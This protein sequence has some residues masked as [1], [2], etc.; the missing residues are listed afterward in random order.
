MAKLQEK[1]DQKTEE[2][3]NL[4]IEYKEAKKNK[5]ANL[6]KKKTKLTKIMV[7]ID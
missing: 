4:K 3:E 2:M 6:E 1:I 5:D 7:K